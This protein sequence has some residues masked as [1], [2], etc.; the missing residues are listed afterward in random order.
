MLLPALTEPLPSFMVAIWTKRNWVHHPMRPVITDFQPNSCVMWHNSAFSTDFPSLK[1][2]YFQ[3]SFHETISVE[4]SVNCR[5]IVS[6]GGCTSSSCVRFLLNFFHMTFVYFSSAVEFLSL[7]F[8]IPLSSTCPVS[9]IF[10]KDILH[11]VPKW[12]GFG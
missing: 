12:E 11:S 3:P 9:S 10:F 1:L 5:W 7:K 6:K 4:P 2:A 8:D